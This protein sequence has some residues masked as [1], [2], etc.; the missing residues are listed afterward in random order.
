MKFS[1]AAVLTVIACVTMCHDLVAAKPMPAPTDDN[2]CQDLD[3]P[4]SKHLC[5][6]YCKNNGVGRSDVVQCGK[7][8]GIC[9][10]EDYKP[11]KR[12]WKKDE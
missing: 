2:K 6:D 4:R 9:Q 11:I 3:D 8:K 5:E 12:E 10:C 1:T 7:Y